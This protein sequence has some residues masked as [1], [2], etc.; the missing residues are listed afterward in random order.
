MPEHSPRLF[1]FLAL[2]AWAVTFAA[3]LEA[4]QHWPW[5]KTVCAVVG[6]FSGSA[7]TLI[8]V[9]FIIASKDEPPPEK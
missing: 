2:M 6:A 5:V 3:I 1:V 8:T 4:W 7:A 9:Y